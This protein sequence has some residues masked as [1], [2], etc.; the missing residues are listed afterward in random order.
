MVEVYDEY[1][2]GLNGHP[3]VAQ[4]ELSHGAKWRSAEKERRFFSRRKIYYDAFDRLSAE[5]GVSPRDVAVRL[6]RMRTDQR[7]SLDAFGKEL[8]RTHLISL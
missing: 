2:Q 8:R 7:K 4:L 5:W 6:E 1:A 3:A